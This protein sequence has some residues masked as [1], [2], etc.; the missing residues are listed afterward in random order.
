MEWLSSDFLR[1]A[2][3][4]FN[5]AEVVIWPVMGVVLLWAAKK[6]TGVNRRDCLLAGFILLIFGASDYFEAENGN[7]WWRPWW[8]F[9]WKAGCVTALV[10]LLIGAWQRRRPQEPRTK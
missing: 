4:V 3:R 6:R 8:L 9:L 2:A 1:D 10:M 5:Y 7:E